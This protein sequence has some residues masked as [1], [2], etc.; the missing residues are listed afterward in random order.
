M[1]RVDEVVAEA[2]AKLATLPSQQVLWE[3]FGE[4]L[5]RLVALEREVADLRAE[6]SRLRKRGRAA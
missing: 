2:Q 5:L 4:W 6:V 3:C 1:D